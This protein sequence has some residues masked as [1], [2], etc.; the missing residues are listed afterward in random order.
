MSLSGA[1]VAGLPVAPTE[2]DL[3]PNDYHAWIF[4]AGSHGTVLK[5][6]DAGLRVRL[7]RGMVNPCGRPVQDER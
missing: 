1:P 6:S 5:S 4:V 2:D 3:T 7:R